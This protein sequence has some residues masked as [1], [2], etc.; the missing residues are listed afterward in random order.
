MGNQ[1]PSVRVRCECGE[2]F[3]VRGLQ[4]QAQ[5]PCPGC[6]RFH[7]V[8]PASS[9]E[10]SCPPSGYTFGSRRQG[11]QLIWV[12]IASAAGII[13][14]VLGVLIWALVYLGGAGG[15]GGHGGEDGDGVG[16]GG[17]GD[18]SGRGAGYGNGSSDVG[19]GD[20][21]S[22]T[23]AGGGA[24]EEQPS[25]KVA[26]DV[27]EEKKTDAN[28]SMPGIE[29]KAGQETGKQI[30]ER[31][32]APLLGIVQVP[33]ETATPRLL[34]KGDFGGQPAKG[35]SGHAG[36]YGGRGE[37]GRNA[38][39]AYGA[40]KETEA[41]VELGL[42]WLAKVQA[43][44]GHWEID[45]RGI[46]QHQVGCTSLAVLCFMGAGYTHQSKKYSETVKNGLA[47]L[48]GTQ[49]AEGRFRIT[50]F[51]EQG[52][53]T[54]ALCEAY[55]MTKDRQ[56]SKKAQM[57][58]DFVISQMG[59]DGGYGYGGP[60]DDVHVTS[61]QVMAIKSAILAGLDVTPKE[62]ILRKLREYYE[63]ALGPDGTTGYTSRA[64]GGSPQTTR[65]AVGLFSRLF[66]ECS[67]KNQDVIKIAEVLHKAGPNVN[68]MFYNYNATYGMF[69]M[70]GKY[71]TDWNGKFRDKVVAMQI[72]NGSNEGSWNVPGHMAQG[73]VLATTMYLMSLEVYY[74]FLPVNK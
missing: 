17:F 34:E 35:L 45:S 71:W 39:K 72:K 66:L 16:K 22:D 52:L 48:T 70:Q 11:K 18:R 68:D 5:I 50:T 8:L 60:G 19:G 54:T 49:D 36:A 65:T 7:T 1:V 32:E 74:R 21:S 61:F 26:G 3:D 30:E 41:A 63:R 62:E 25:D 53:A 12:P 43:S 28:A 31:Q 47:W 13:L 23:G 2:V 59:K 44:D 4:T 51:Y 6:N 73:D 20:G 15:R 64:G 38:G 69:Q 40:T 42:A 67:P 27:A 24:P 57:A 10:A 46:G 9:D 14:L 55:G 58:V 29:K 56:F 37:G 33:T